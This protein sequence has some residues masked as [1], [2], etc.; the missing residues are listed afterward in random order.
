MG[1]PR[2]KYLINNIFGLGVELTAGASPRYSVY[3]YPLG[4][5]RCCA[6]M[7]KAC[8]GLRQLD[9]ID[10]RHWSLQTIPEEVYR[11]ERTLEELLLDYNQIQDLPPASIII[12]QRTG[13]GS[14]P[15]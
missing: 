1:V 13:P 11:H 15:S 9:L 6:E 5:N 8:I 3:L 12:F 4:V 7:L 2:I 14:H 10:R